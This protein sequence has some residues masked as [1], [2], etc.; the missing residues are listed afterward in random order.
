MTPDAIREATTSAPLSGIRS[1]SQDVDQF[2]EL[3]RGADLAEAFGIEEDA[4]QQAIEDRVAELRRLT[5][6]FVDSLAEDDP[7]RAELLTRSSEA[8]KRLRDPI[9][10]FILLRAAFMRLDPSDP[11]VRAELELDYLRARVPMLVRSTDLQAALRYAE[12]YYELAP[13]DPLAIANVAIARHRT[14]PGHVERQA[15]LDFL[16]AASSTEARADA[17]E[18]HLALAELAID[19]GRDAL[20]RRALE[21][22]EAIS[23]RDPRIQQLKQIY[24]E[25]RGAPSMREPASQRMSRPP[26]SMR[27]MPTQPP[28][29]RASM[30]PRPP[31]I[32]APG[33]AQAGFFER[34][35][36]PNLPFVLAGV[37][38][39]A[40]GAFWLLT[41]KSPEADM[42]NFRLEAVFFCDRVKNE[43][44]T[45]I[46]EVERAR[47]EA[48]TPAEKAQ[49]LKLI[50]KTEAEKGQT[51][52]EMRDMQKGDTLASAP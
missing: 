40:G 16:I 36:Q 43:G 14:A 12:R 17:I 34:V 31:S 52:L 44:T 9:E 39:L 8:E 38:L 51:K 27:P 47:W 19:A 24:R 7:R 23:E 6:H 48:L 22:A 46:C 15:V 26:A 30:G 50:L 10:R 21:A 5:Q 2:L 33:E 32:A 3:L 18:I 49:R 28:G 42:E 29:A 37:I 41:A 4:P 45:T 35:I 25:L 1:A 11:T 20:V 13:D